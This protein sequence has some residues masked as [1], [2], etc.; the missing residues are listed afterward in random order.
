MVRRRN[1][2]MR[3][4]MSKL[5]K[6]MI[7]FAVSFNLEQI[8]IITK[9]D[10]DDEPAPPVHPKLRIKLKL[11]TVAS[12]SNSPGTTPDVEL[13]PSKR[14]RAGISLFFWL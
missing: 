12:S 3:T 2:R 13:S 6:R 8:L 9:G 4:K 7:R 11:P 1:W 5:R 14:R 10:E